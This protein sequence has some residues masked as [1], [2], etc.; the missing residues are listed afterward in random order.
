MEA[1]DA[2]TVLEKSDLDK[3]FEVSKPVKAFE[4]LGSESDCFHNSRQ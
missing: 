2:K 3:I 1:E 4:I